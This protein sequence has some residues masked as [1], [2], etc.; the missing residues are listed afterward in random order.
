MNTAAEDPNRDDIL[1]ALAGVAMAKHQAWADHTTHSG[2]GEL[3]SNSTRPEDQPLIRENDRLYAEYEDLAAQ[4]VDSPAFTP[5]GWKA[6]AAVY[7]QFVDADGPDGLAGLLVTSL[8]TD[9]LG[10]PVR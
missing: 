8:M 3:Y 6:K 9:M 5:E 2:F 4:V 7:W 10:G 1:I